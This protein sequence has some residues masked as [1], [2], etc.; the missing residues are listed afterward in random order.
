MLRLERSG[1]GGYGPASDRDPQMF[2]DDVRNGYVS[3]EAAAADYGVVI[4]PKTL[5]VAD[6]P[7]AR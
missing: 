4:D 3:L 2:A 7:A 1:G 5:T 6:A